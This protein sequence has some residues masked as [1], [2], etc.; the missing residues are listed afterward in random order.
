MSVERK[1]YRI[2]TAFAA[3]EVHSIDVRFVI[4]LLMVANVDGVVHDYTA[5]KLLPVKVFNYPDDPVDLW[6]DVIDASWRELS[7]MLDGM[8]T[9]WMVQGSAELGVAHERL[10]KVKREATRRSELQRSR[11]V[12]QTKVCNN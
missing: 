9:V 6:D 3:F 2:E 8:R 7:E 5:N 10:G 11:F 12:R 4:L 1:R